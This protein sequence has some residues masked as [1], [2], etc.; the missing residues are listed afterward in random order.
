MEELN[1][2]SPRGEEFFVYIGTYTSRGSKGIHLARFNAGSGRLEMIGL[3]AELPDPSYLAI[4]PSGR[5]LYCVSRSN[6]PSG[7]R[8]AY[9][10]VFAIERQTGRLT[11]LN[12]QPSG[13]VGPCFV[14]LDSAGRCALVA[15]Y[16]SGTAAIF[17]VGNDGRLGE[18]TDVIQHHGSSIIPK[19]QEGPHA[20]SITPS[21]DDRFALAADLGTDRIIVYRLDAAKA[22][23]TLNDPPSVALKPGSGPRHLAFHPRQPLVYVINEL[24]S[25]MTAFDWNS[26]RGAL[27]EVQTVS[28][29]PPDFHGTNSCAD[30]HAAPSG[31]FLYGSNRGHDS[32]T[33]YRI[34]DTDGTLSV[35]SYQ[36]VLGK[37]P[38]NFTLDPSGRWLLAANAGMGEGG[39]LPPEQLNPRDENITVFRVDAVTGRLS[40]TGHS[41]PVSVPVC[42]KLLPCV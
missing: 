10:N 41:I 1:M 31:R 15:N 32:V 23:M 20:H 27:R 24:A 13:G 25:T 8:E 35:V 14:S 29:L 37:W 3:A 12:R 39:P 30:V 18:A 38:R 40:P 11:F 21:P 42:V 22:R 6:E 4:H 19:R 9:V 34:A 16:G 2:A 7:R 33:I 28:T 5:F 26:S 36:P 17:P